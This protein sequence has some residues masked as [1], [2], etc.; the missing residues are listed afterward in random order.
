MPEHKDIEY[1]WGMPVV[2]S[3]LVPPGQVLFTNDQ[4]FVRDL[5]E[6]ERWM[7]FTIA[8][9]VEPMQNSTIDTKYFWKRVAERAVKTFAQTSAALLGAGAVNILDVPWYDLLGV[10]ATA[11][12]LSVLTSIASI[13][14]G[15]DKGD[16]SAV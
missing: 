8:G 6:V 16:A 11:T 10:S 5:E 7:A 4:A 14:L 12:V 1:P 15:E 2:V 9:N 3:S 13:P